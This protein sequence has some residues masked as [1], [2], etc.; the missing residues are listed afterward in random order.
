MNPLRILPLVRNACALVPRLPSAPQSAGAARALGAL[1]CA[2]LAACQ[3]GPAPQSTRSAIDAALAEARA[4]RT[5]PRVPERVR[6]ALVSAP[7]ALPAAAAPLPEQRFDLV[8]TN[9]PAA[10][11]FQA[12]GSGSRYSVLLPP[13]LPGTVSVNLKEV[14]VHEALDVMREL[15]GFEYRLEGT[16]IFVQPAALGT[17]VFQIAYPSARRSGRSDTRV[18]S[19]S[20]VAAAPGGGAAAATGAQEGSQVSTLQEA[21]FWKEIDAALKAVVGSGEGRQVVLSPHSGVLVVRAMPREQREVEQYLRAARVAIERQVMLEAK[22]VEVSLREGF[23]SGINWAAFDRAGNHRFSSGIDASRVNVPGS[24]GRAAGVPTGSVSTF[25]DATTTPATVVPS[26]LG[27]LLSSPLASGNSGALG[28]AFTTNSFVG[29]LAFLETQG[30][31]QV[32]SSPRV[33]ATNNQKA[34]LRVGS[35]DFFITNV[36]ATTTTTAAGSVTTPTIQTQAFFSGISLDVT[37]QI[38]EEGMVTLHIRPSV[39]VVS[40]R[41][42]IINLGNLGSFTLPLAS[43]NINEAD[44]VVRVADGVTVAIGGLMSQTQNH[45]DQR[46]PGAGDVPVLGEAFKR[47]QRQLTKRELVFLLKP[48]V[49][50]GESQWAADIARAETRLR[51]LP[52][53]PRERLPMPEASGRSAVPGAG[54]GPASS[55][56][57]GDA[58]AP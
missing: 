17:R 13:N 19:G 44:T 18:V 40:E 43:A 2:L 39:S 47:V 41:T 31:V 9:A 12:I 26:T 36:T 37:P 5:P 30:T 21:D 49:I 15:Y 34:V 29:L 55:T 24:L 45:D 52:S 23:E 8:V 56:N 33:A 38:D 1:A 25:V 28:L 35:D 3:L 4:E 20:I 58:T 50:K 48:T 57:P 10:Q 46:V 6:D 16:R 42:R 32:L 54:T 7:G 53:A 27:Q 51:A 14:S 22:I 11:V